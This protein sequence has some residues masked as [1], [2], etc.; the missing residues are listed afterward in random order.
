MYA[1][2]SIGDGVA[3]SFPIYPLRT[4]LF[5]IISIL[6]LFDGIPYPAKEL[7]ESLNSKSLRYLI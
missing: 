2:P 7:S 3:P 5:Y 6:I 4:C 1:T